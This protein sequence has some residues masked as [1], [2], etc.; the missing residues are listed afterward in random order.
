MLFF[1]KNGF[2]GSRMRAETTLKRELGYSKGIL[3]IH[4]SSIKC[5]FEKKLE[6]SVF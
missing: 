2:E 6:G 4:P 5:K 3:G 1:S